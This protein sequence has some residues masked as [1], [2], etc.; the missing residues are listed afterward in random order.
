[1]RNRRPRPNAVVE[2]VVLVIDLYLQGAGVRGAPL[3]PDHV[4]LVVVAVCPC[5]RQRIFRFFGEVAFIVV[6]IR[7]RAIAGQ[8]IARAGARPRCR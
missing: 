3:G 6:R 8:A 7:P 1:M 5:F 4:V 2:D